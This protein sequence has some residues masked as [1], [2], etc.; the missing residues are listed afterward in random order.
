[1]TQADQPEAFAADLEQLM[2]RYFL[3]FDLTYASMIGVL[4]IATHSLADQA[5]MNDDDRV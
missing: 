5:L 4:H 2:L 1:M 3:E